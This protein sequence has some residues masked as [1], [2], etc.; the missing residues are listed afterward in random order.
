MVEDV[1]DVGGATAAG[2]GTSSPSIEAAGLAEVVFGIK[3]AFGTSSP[4]TEALR[5]GDVRESEI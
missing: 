1:A 2:F 5:S 3:A 4:S